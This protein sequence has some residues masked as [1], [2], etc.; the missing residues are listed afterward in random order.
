MR[1]V[2]AISLKGFE[3]LAERSL[4]LDA[5]RAIIALEAV[6]PRA[7]QRFVNVWTQRSF[8]RYI[9]DEALLIAFLRKVMP[10]YLGEAVE[11]FRGQQRGDRTGVS[12]TFSAHIALKFAMFGEQ[13]ID[14]I[15]L[16]LDGP[17]DRRPR[18]DGVILRAFVPASSIICAP[19]LLTGFES[20]CIIDPRGMEFE[21]LPAADAAGWIRDE[22]AG[23]L[24]D[25]GEIAGCVYAIGSRHGRSADE[26]L[27]LLLERAADAGDLEAEALVE[28]GLL[29]PFLI[30]ILSGLN[31]PAATSP[32]V[33]NH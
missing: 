22:L 27:D 2:G 9:P 8:G 6:H 24:D 20:E 29:H 12:W 5:V 1:G 32:H 28:S 25:L 11:L 4:W 26:P 17:G 15:D 16:T 31:K 33:L 30:Q 23:A 7:Q 13:N 19:C 21:T 18:A 10:P 3:G 14:P